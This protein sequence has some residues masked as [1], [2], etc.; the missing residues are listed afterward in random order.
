MSVIDSL[1]T[2]RIGGFYNASDLN[3]VEAAVEYL[4]EQFDSLPS[5][6]AEYLESLNVAQDEFFA[7]PYEYPLPIITKTNWTL[8]DTQKKGELDRYLDNV[9]TLKETITL[10]GDTPELPTS[11]KDLLVN[12]AN[13]I[14]KVLRI[15]NDATLALEALK[16]MYA[17]NTAAAF[18]YSGELF[19]G[20][21]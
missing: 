9:K 10:P 6:L 18:W 11:M 12:D 21:V 5:V 2:D 13:N 4:T 19:S 3:R 14:E 16:K 8:V 15:V 1:I 7:V 20:E 17:D